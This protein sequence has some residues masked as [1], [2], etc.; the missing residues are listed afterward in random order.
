ME[1]TRQRIMF[2]AGAALMTLA[3]LC[4]CSDSTSSTPTLPRSGSQSDATTLDDVRRIVS[5]QLGVELRK[6]APSTSLGEL[7]ADEL[8]FVELVMEL[9]ERFDITIPDDKVTQMTG[10]NALQHGMK[11]VTMEKLA[12]LVDS[13][14]RN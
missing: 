6:L 5:E 9:E 11:N 12:A 2:R 10:S 3:L 4:G 14:K 8:D 1:H 13:V 7:G